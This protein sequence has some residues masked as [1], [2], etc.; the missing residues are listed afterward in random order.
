[1]KC[2]MY[3]DFVDTLYIQDFHLHIVLEKR[4]QVCQQTRQANVKRREV[5]KFKSLDSIVKDS[6]THKF[7]GAYE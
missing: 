2:P 4:M 1:M 7:E 6:V 5:R 3:P